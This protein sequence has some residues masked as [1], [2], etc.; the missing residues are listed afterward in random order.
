MLSL[1]HRIW[2]SY[3]STATIDHDPL[4]YSN[5]LSSAIERAKAAREYFVG[6]RS[7][8]TG[9]NNILPASLE[10][11]AD[12]ALLEN[13]FW[14]HG[15]IGTNDIHLSETNL[16]NPMFASIPIDTLIFHHGTHPLLGFHLATAYLP[17]TATFPL[18]P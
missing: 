9:V 6:S 10:G 5:S 17:L 14:D 15:I 11:L 16:S 3:F 13:R 4:T 18:L 12:L 8:L 2:K 7:V 1:L